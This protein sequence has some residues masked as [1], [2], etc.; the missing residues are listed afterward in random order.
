MSEVKFTPEIF[1]QT[2]LVQAE[3]RKLQELLDD[4]VR[5]TTFRYCAEEDKV[6]MLPDLFKREKRTREIVINEDDDEDA[7]TWG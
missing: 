2:D 5:D 7:A 4:K 1:K 3:C 6:I